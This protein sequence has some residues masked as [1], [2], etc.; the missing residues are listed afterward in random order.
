[1]NIPKDEHWWPSGL[2][3]LHECTTYAS[4][5]LKNHLGQMSPE[6][7]IAG[8]KAN[9][10]ALSQQSRLE[11][12]VITL[13]DFVCYPVWLPYSLVEVSKS[14]GSSTKGRTQSDDLHEQFH[15]PYPCN[16]N[17]RLQLV[18]EP[19][20]YLDKDDMVAGWY[21]P[22]MIGP[23]ISRSVFEATKRAAVAPN[24]I[25]NGKKTGNWRDDRSTY[26]DPSKCTIPPGNAN[27]SVGW[28]AR[29]QAAKK[30]HL[31]PSS[32]LRQ[33]SGIAFLQETHVAAGIVGAMLSIIHPEV[34]EAHLLVLLEMHWMRNCLADPEFTKAVFEDWQSPFSAFAIIAN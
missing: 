21:I 27:I 17:G 5:A 14:F 29:G 2:S 24:S 33:E 31:M 32:I 3:L 30:E 34:Y 16:K 13:A 28:Y 8:A 15:G 25:F 22:N 4:L 9:S 23:D 10:L 7:Y 12:M 19:T 11:T 18:D 26:A 20:V 6:E 1:M